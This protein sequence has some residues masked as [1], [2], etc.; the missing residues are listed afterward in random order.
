MRAFPFASR[1]LKELIRDPMMIIFA[2]GFPVVLLLM[3]S[4]IHSHAPVNLFAISKLSPGIAVF[5]LSFISLFS[6]MLI[7][8][9]RC[10]SFL[11]R[12]FASPLSA[13]DYILGYI[14]PLLPIAI[15]QSVVCFVLSFFLG[16]SV[17]A[18]VLAALLV[19]IPTSVLFIGTGL[20]MGTLVNDKAVGG[21]A[22]IIINLSGWLSGTWFNLNLVGGTFKA[23]SDVLPFANAV[24]AARAA[25]S[26]DYAAI[27]P[28]LLWV[29]GYAV[30]VLVISVVL[31]RRKMMNAT[32]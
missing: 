12:L 16:L 22:S 15:I 27:L 20:L 21:I 31:F 19:L 10:S 30:A 9:D 24:N 2:I 28:S 18:N 8:K 5:G 25:I 29:I 13:S 17:T 3:L 11:M 6:G 23:I 14:L 32:T 7:A 26:G 1:N 4:A